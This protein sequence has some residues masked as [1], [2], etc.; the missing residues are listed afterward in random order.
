MVGLIWLTVSAGAVW[1]AD[2]RPSPLLTRDSL[3]TEVGFIT[4]FGYSTVTEGDYLPIPVILHLG[5]DMKRWFPSLADNR[6]VLTV[7]LEPQV[8]PVFGYDISMEA[9]L[10]IGLK[11][12]YPLTDALSVYGLFSTG[13]LFITGDTV[14]QASG[15]NFSHAVG[16]GINVN[17]MPGGALDLG[18]R[19]RH[20]SNADL[21]DPN[22][23]ID[24]YI[25]TIGFMIS[26]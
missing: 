10:G 21:R 1:S 20:V 5:T 26:Y 23:G 3:F 15:F 13:F 14:D 24:S 2:E 18:F 11:Y 6:G 12:R 8:N 22:C 7:F 4:G 25:G 17:V 9:G 19:I 16:V